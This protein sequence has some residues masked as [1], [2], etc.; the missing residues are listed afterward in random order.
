MS[1]QE[2]KDAAAATTLLHACAAE[3]SKAQASGRL[4]QWAAMA[5]SIIDLLAAKESKD[6]SPPSPDPVE[7]EGRG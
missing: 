5:H 3:F 2:A 1:P 7:G 6:A 4:R